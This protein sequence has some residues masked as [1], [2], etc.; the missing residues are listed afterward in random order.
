MRRMVDR[1]V[2]DGVIDVDDDV[3]WWQVPEVAEADRTHR[4]VFRRVLLM[5]L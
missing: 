5:L 4:S 2:I 3:R 1:V